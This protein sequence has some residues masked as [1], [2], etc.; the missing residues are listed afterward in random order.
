MVLLGCANRDPARWK[1]PDA[2]DI[3]RLRKAHIGF[4]FGPHVCLGIHIA[5][6]EMSIWLNRLLS[7][8]PE[9]EFAGDVEFGTDFTLRGVRGVPIKAA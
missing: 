5:R 1:N 6:M 9:Y 2:F 3:F 4:G 7:K 8:L